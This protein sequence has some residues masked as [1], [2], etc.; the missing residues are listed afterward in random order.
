[1]KNI[2]IFDC[3]VAEIFAKLYED[4][5]VPATLDLT[6]LDTKAISDEDE[7]EE[8]FHKISVYEH[9][10]RWLM[11]AGYINVENIN[12]QRAYG[13]VLSAKGLEILKMPVSLQ[14]PKESLGEFIMD[15]MKAGAKE[16][17][18][19]QAKL[20]ITRGLALLSQYV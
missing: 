17:A 15:A 19:S 8:I 7:H 14:Q 12:S 18:A 1:M 20:A 5:P 3:Y 4:F 10:V 16:S 6:W 2:E 11:S 13:A 9:T